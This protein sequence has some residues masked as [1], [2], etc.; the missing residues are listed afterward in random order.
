M[1]SASDAALDCP[2]AAAKVERWSEALIANAVVRQV[3]RRT[4]LCVPN[5]VWTGHEC[6][7]LCVDKSLRVI[8]VEIKISR[9]DLKA[10]HFKDKWTRWTGPRPYGAPRPPRVLRDWPTRVWRHYYVLPADVW[11]PELLASLPSQKSGVVTIARENPDYVY[12]TGGYVAKV[13][14]R[15]RSNPDA[16]QLTST[17]VID[18]ARLST[19]RLWSVRLGE[20][21]L[22]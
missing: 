13:V 16:K 21:V 10:D 15:A 18:I 6:D 11:T 17:Q 20:G 22:S 8:D 4:V 14:R 2:R 5:C 19:L 1:N 3:F 12:A 9:A 7:L